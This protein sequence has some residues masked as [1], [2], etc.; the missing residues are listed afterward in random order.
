MRCQANGCD[1][2]AVATATDALLTVMLCGEHAATAATVNL[3]DARAIA[4]PS[5]AETLAEIARL[6]ATLP[7]TYRAVNLHGVAAIAALE[8]AGGRR[9]DWVSNS[10]GDPHVMEHCKLT[11]GGVEFDAIESRPATDEERAKLAEPDQVIEESAY[12][13]AH[14]G[15]RAA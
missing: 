5:P 14:F 10:G 12:V 15:G 3:H 1:K 11:I 2:S 13:N 9:N 6:V 4:A 7:A 8:S